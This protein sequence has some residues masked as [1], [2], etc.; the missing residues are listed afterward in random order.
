MISKYIFSWPFK[1]SQIKR[2]HAQIKCSFPHMNRFTQFVRKSSCWLRDVSPSGGTSSSCRSTPPSSPSASATS[3][4]RPVLKGI[5]C[6]V[7]AYYSLVS[8]RLHKS[9]KCSREQLKWQDCKKQTIAV[10][11]NIRNLQ[12]EYVCCVASTSLSAFLIWNHG[13]NI[14][15]R[16]LHGKVKQVNKLSN[17]I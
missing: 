14:H 5:W 17:C 12:W 11:C 4:R 6:F 10:K 2:R 16:P 15:C 1:T 13:S 7:P 9:I 8:K 3:Q